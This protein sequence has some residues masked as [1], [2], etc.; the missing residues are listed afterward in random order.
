MLQTL[1]LEWCSGDPDF[2]KK[3]GDDERRPEGAAAR[4]R[5]AKGVGQRADCMLSWLSG[6]FEVYG[7]VQDSETRSASAP[8]PIMMHDDGAACWFPRIYDLFLPL[9]LSVYKRYRFT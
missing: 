9:R 2:A 6:V 4:R 5:A 7:Q 1:R 3:W 8:R